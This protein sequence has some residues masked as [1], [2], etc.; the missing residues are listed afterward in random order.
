MAGGQSRNTSGRRTTSGRTISGRDIGLPGT[1]HGHKGNL[2]FRPLP[3][4]S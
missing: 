2:L 1:Q 4:Q 3:T